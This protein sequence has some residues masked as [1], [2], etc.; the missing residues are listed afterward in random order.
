MNLVISITLFVVIVFIFLYKRNSRHSS[1]SQLKRPSL[2]VM[3]NNKNE[4]LYYNSKLHKFEFLCGD[5][6]I[7]IFSI[8][9]KGNFICINDSLVYEIAIDDNRRLIVERMCKPSFRVDDTVGTICANI[10]SDT[11]NINSNN[12]TS[13]C[14]LLLTSSLIFVNYKYYNKCNEKDRIRIEYINKD[15]AFVD[16]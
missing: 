10:E 14:C 5:S 13:P 7:S 1:V 12:E 9:E 16:D 6:P 11:S 8:T 4:W 2:F 15:D 3:L